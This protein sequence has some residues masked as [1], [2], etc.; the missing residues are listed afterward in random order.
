MINDFAAFAGKKISIG[1]ISVGCGDAGLHQAICYVL[2]SDGRTAFIFQGHQGDE[3]VRDN[4]FIQVSLIEPPIVLEARKS[5]DQFGRPALDEIQVR[6]SIDLRWIAHIYEI[7]A[8]KE[9]LPT[10]VA[11]GFSDGSMIAF[12]ANISGP[13]TVVCVDSN[14][15]GFLKTYNLLLGP[16]AGPDF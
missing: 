10:G 1:K 15:E 16:R 7:S 2:R 8:K 5:A 12:Q 13:G 6:E 14:V 3:E 11:L 9:G 4:Q